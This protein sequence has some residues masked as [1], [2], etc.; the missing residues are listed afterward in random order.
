MSQQS[1]NYENMPSA[2]EEMWPTFYYARVL[3]T[4]CAVKVSF[5]FLARLKK[6]DFR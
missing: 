4:A 6:K 2:A 1:H 5:E 3:T